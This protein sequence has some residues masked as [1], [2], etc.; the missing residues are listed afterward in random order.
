MND[1]VIECF[2][3]FI[4]SKPR[5]CENSNYK[6]SFGR[7]KGKGTSII[8]GIAIFDLC[9]ISYNLTFCVTDFVQI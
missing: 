1:C 6:G 2:V 3:D 8:T 7:K 9:N 4:C 5:I